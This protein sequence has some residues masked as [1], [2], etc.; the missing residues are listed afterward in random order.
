MFLKDKDELDKSNCYKDDSK[1]TGM[2]S[3]TTKNRKMRRDG[4]EDL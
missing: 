3:T 1:T 2:Q 4:D